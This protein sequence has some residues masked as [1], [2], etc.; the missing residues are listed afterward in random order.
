MNCNVALR[1]SPHYLKNFG[2]VGV[3]CVWFADFVANRTPVRPN[4]QPQ[5]YCGIHDDLRERFMRVPLLVAFNS[6]VDAITIVLSP[7]FGLFGVAPF[8]R[9]RS[10]ISSVVPMIGVVLVATLSLAFKIF[11]V[12]RLPVIPVIEATVFKDV[13]S[14]LSV[15]FF[16]V[17]LL[18][19][20]VF[21]GHREYITTINVPTQEGSV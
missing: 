9:I 1:T 13:L 18:L 5:S 12:N 2:V 10:L 3:V 14:V 8:L 20:R 7:F 16:V 17:L 4:E 21:V 6:L 11:S 19:F 15:L